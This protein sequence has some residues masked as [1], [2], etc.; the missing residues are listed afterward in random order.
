MIL[1]ECIIFILIL[2]TYDLICCYRILN[3][4]KFKSKNNFKLELSS[5][6]ELNK[7]KCYVLLNNIQSGSNI[8]KICR[9]CLAFNVH[10]VLIIGKKDFKSKMRQ[11]D[12]GSKE[13]LTFKNFL[14]IL[15]AKEYLKSK[16]CT[17]LGVEIM[18][19]SISITKNPF[20]TDTAFIFGNEG[21][22]LSDK[23]KSI[24]DGF[25]YIPQYAKEGMASINVACASAIILQH[26]ANWANYKESEILLEKFL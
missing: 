13:R 10:E 18:N 16:N 26:F 1:K 20:Y 8:G 21:G 24:C 19:K 6:V 7:P 25:V 4:N 3:S 5:E 11:A 14:T 23:Q 2:I 22:G 15:D 17:I 12:R 9:N